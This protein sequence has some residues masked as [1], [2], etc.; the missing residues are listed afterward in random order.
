MM[1]L[2]YSVI[3]FDYPFNVRQPQTQHDGFVII[4]FHFKNITSSE[5]F[6]SNSMK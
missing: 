2:M 5:F 4:P 1:Y 6:I 3:L